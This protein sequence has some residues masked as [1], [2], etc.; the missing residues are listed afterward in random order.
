MTLCQCN[1][2]RR[3]K[4]ESSVFD[5]KAPF[6]KVMTLS[7]S[8]DFLE[9]KAYSRFKAVKY[10]VTLQNKEGSVKIVNGTT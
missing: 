1:S 7:R 4:S 5:A 9:K 6:F 8:Q 2:Q 10:N 3:L